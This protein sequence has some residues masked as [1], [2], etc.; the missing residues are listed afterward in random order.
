M[1]ELIY[2]P[3]SGIF[4]LTQPVQLVRVVKQWFTG[5]IV[6]ELH[7]IRILKTN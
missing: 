1:H 2:D 6:G 3:N 7:F 5:R 4:L